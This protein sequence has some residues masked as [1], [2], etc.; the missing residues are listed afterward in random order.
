M[1]FECFSKDESTYG[2]LAASYEV[3]EELGERA[4]GTTNIDYSET[5]Y[6]EFQKIRSYKTTTLDI[7][8]SGFDV[9]TSRWR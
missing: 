4:N 9:K 7:D 5:L 1:F 6:G 2:R 3:F 8:P